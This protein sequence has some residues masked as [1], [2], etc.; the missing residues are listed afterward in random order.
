MARR[1]THVIEASADGVG[2]MRQQYQ[3]ARNAGK[4][5][6]VVVWA[7]PTAPVEMLHAMDLVVMWPLH[8]SLLLAAKQESVQYL[9]VTEALGYHK[10]LCRYCA[11][12]S[13]GAILSDK[14]SDQLPWGG[15]GKP[16]AILSPSYCDSI[17]KAM[18]DMGRKVSTPVF[19][20][21]QVFPARASSYYGLDSIG[22]HA[23]GPVA[24]D[25][26][27]ID[28]RVK[29]FEELTVYLEDRTGKTLNERKLRQA[30][31]FSSEAWDYWG[32][33]EDMRLS[34]PCPVSSSEIFACV[35][36]PLFFRGTQFA[37]DHMRKMRDE[38]RQRVDE[39]TGVVDQEKYR[40]LWCGYP[41]WFNP[42][43]LNA[44]E[45]QL[46]AV[47]AWENYHF[48]RF[49]ASLDPRQPMEAMASE[50]MDMGAE[51]GL[52]NQV[53]GETFY[54]AARIPGNIDGVILSRAESCKPLS[55]SIARY[56]YEFQKMG[57]P[58]LELPLDYIDPRGWDEARVTSRIT[59]FLET[60]EPKPRKPKRVYPRGTYASE[61]DWR[62]AVAGV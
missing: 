51:L 2:F 13:L 62:R 46:G 34:V 23:P 10:D 54:P 4:T 32:Q 28:Y 61:A 43:F 1:M 20:T 37:A 19:F 58:Y 52:C 33:V 44:F 27:R 42:G 57:I 41:V 24:Q 35:V 12:G 50:I 56:K 7:G 31:Q 49:C 60:I 26:R 18:E 22:W 30:V 21:D 36:S 16:H 14:P 40:L 5:G 59:E 39:G 45:E 8:Y 17:V 48:P 38:V 3:R 11:R 53:F 47:F 25:A 55:S 29:A 6:E 9:E 15:I